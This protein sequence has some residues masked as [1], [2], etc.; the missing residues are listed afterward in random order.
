M[1]A[2]RAGPRGSENGWHDP[3]RLAERLAAETAPPRRSRLFPLRPPHHPPIRRPPHRNPACAL[4][5]PPTDPL[6]LPPDPHRPAARPHVPYE[7]RLTSSPRTGTCRSLLLRPQERPTHVLTHVP[8]A[9]DSSLL[10]PRSRSQPPQ[11]S[12]A[13]CTQTANLNH[14]I[15]ADLPALAPLHILAVRC[16]IQTG[17]SHIGRP[18]PTVPWLRLTHDQLAWLARQSPVIHPR[19][20]AVPEAQLP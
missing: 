1:T 14:Q 11:P 17:D 15:L 13:A 16:K 4:L 6:R 5:L 19:P 8:D 9:P 3:K 18:S 20:P 2:V 10:P 7:T 12:P